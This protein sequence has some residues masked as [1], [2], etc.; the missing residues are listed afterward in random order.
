MLPARPQRGSCPDEELILEKATALEEPRVEEGVSGEMELGSAFEELIDPYRSPCPSPSAQK[1]QRGPFH[2][3][4]VLGPE[5]PLLTSAHCLFREPSCLD[6][7][8]VLIASASTSARWPDVRGVSS[9]ELNPPEIS[10][11]KVHFALAA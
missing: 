8:H 1:G 4:E 10:V 7:G 6:G 11:P 5:F 2:S 9:W 3:S